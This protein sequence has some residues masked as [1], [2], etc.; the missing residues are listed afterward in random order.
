MKTKALSIIFYFIIFTAFGQGN[1]LYHDIQKAKDSKIHFEK[2]SLKKTSADIQTLNNFKNKNEVL[3]F[4]DFSIESENGNTKALNLT[5]PLNNKNMI[6]ELIEVTEDYYDYVIETSSGQLFSADRDIK[7]F[8]G[9]IKDDDNSI[10]A[11][12]L[13]K[14]EIMGLICND[15]G[16]F[17][18]TKDKDTG[19]HVLYNDRNLINKPN[20]TCATVDDFSF[21]YD[22]KILTQD[23]KILINDRGS[24]GDT[25]RF[26]VETMY[27]IYDAHGHSRSAVEK[28]IT[29]IFNQVST[30]YKNEYIPTKISRIKVW[31]YIDPY[32]LWT[33]I[34]N[35][36]IR[37]Q[38]ERTS[39][40][41][42]LGILLT[43]EKNENNTQEGLAAGFEGL[44]NPS[45]KEK[46]AVA[47]INKGYAAYADYSWTVNV[48]THELGHL[49][50]SRHT[51][52]C[53]WNDGFTAID[54]CAEVE[55][56]CS[57]PG[58]P[59]GA[60]TIMSYC[61]QIDGVGIN[62]I[63]GF[64]IQ[65]NTVIFN[66]Y[67]FADC[68]KN[69]DDEFSDRTVVSN[70][71]VTGCETLI[72]ENVSISDS[73]KVILSATK[74]IDVYSDFHAAEGTDVTIKINA[75]SDSFSSY[76]IS[77]LPSISEAEQLNDLKFQEINM[78][79]VEL[80]K[81]NSGLTVFPIPADKI[82]NIY[83]TKS[84]NQLYIYNIHGVLMCNSLFYQNTSL[85][86]STWPAAIYILRIIQEDKTVFSQKFIKE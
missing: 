84:N 14:N 60:G 24:A 76:Y 67:F 1:A 31:D 10:V 63:N 29:S 51:H 73:A 78:D 5:I 7:H 83:S 20:M 21:S 80:T 43:Y 56:N 9:V 3:F 79:N 38:D 16:N 82:L 77:D 19:K 41:G 25:V 57:R 30:L 15:E 18:L 6:L 13:Y 34:N 26:Y 52:A 36:L 50:G 48:I 40:P 2:V 62:F 66:N 35:L 47:M 23:K 58:Y 49:L 74:E 42:D 32:Y 70:I 12:T 17:N 4:E 37:F 44:C 28:H 27:D 61:H 22:P 46:L 11:L 68:L 53:V 85:D 59:E 39:F 54:G 71:T 86:I 65:P 69:C 8:R 81:N 64:G 45:A 33:D 55:G 75:K 72:V